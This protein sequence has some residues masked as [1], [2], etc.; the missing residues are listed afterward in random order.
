MRVKVF[1]HCCTRGSPAEENLSN[2]K[3]EAADLRRWI[4]ARRSFSKR[5][6]ISAP[7]PPFLRGAA[8][9]ERLSGKSLS[10]S[11]I[12]RVLKRLGFSQKNGLWG[13]WNET[14]G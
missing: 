3:G 6:Y 11:T 4:K 1:A 14:S 8:L 12:R 13:R 9:L 2:Q 10:D 5:T 7:R